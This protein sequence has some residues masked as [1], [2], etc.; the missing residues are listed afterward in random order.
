MSNIPAGSAHANDG[1]KWYAL[2]SNG[3]KEG[4]DKVG[5]A[6]PS[7]MPFGYVDPSLR[8]DFGEFRSF[9]A[10]A[11]SAFNMYR[12]QVSNGGYAGLESVMRANAMQD[13]PG[14]SPADKG[15]QIANWQ[16]LALKNLAV[17]AAQG[18]PAALRAIAQT[19]SDMAEGI[20]TDQPTIY[21]QRG[22]PSDNSYETMAA[23][24]LVHQQRLLDK[25]REIGACVPTAQGPQ[26][27][28]LRVFDHISASM[29][30]QSG[31]GIAPALYYVADDGNVAIHPV[32]PFDPAHVE[33]AGFTPGQHIQFALQN[34]KV[35][36]HEGVQVG[37][38]YPFNHHFVGAV[39]AEMKKEVQKIQ[40]DDSHANLRKSM[41]PGTASSALEPS[42]GN[43]GRLVRHNEAYSNVAA[44][45]RTVS[46]H[47]ASQEPQK[48]QAS[49]SD[50]A[51][52]VSE[53]FAGAG[54]KVESAFSPANTFSSAADVTFGPRGASSTRRAGQH[55][56]EAAPRHMAALWV[57]RQKAVEGVHVGPYAS[58]PEP[59]EFFVSKISEFL[60]GMES[61]SGKARLIAAGLQK[62]LQPNFSSMGFG[63]LGK[64][65]QPTTKGALP[66]LSLK[67]IALDVHNAD[68]AW[69]RNNGLQTLVTPGHIA[70]EARS[71]MSVFEQAAA[72]NG[73]AVPS[74]M[75]T[76]YK[77]DSNGPSMTLVGFA[78][79]ANQDLTMTNA[80]GKE[81]PVPRGTRLFSGSMLVREGSKLTQYDMQT[82]N[83]GTMHEE[84]GA[85]DSKGEVFRFWDPHHDAKQGG[86][87]ISSEATVSDNRNTNGSNESTRAGSMFFVFDE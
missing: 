84:A 19:Q 4:S 33:L 68:I 71:A 56:K 12:D 18:D 15:E 50:L 58:G 66:Q 11:A 32:H 26:P 83:P 3:C 72:R 73:L 69:A 53:F 10:T 51:R 44:E 34:R 5:N 65:I 82:H 54:R 36:V 61:A 31:G 16:Q 37:I 13:F 57:G 47:L 6:A 75:A 76:G 22:V 55:V 64:Y 29:P 60:N 21:E 59:N 74:K 23:L 17:R 35:A 2:G 14:F 67:P 48:A 77:L 27:W 30:Q 28:P 85:S 52:G 46:K 62:N 43:A 38:E 86:F 81:V 49:L 40:A 25:A 20:L 8:N 24:P 41:L 42:I 9:P 45:L 80:H 7:N 1:G 63:D 70:N 39:M 78:A 79:R 87:A